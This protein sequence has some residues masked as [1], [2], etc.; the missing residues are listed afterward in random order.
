V[1]AI[2]KPL[3][4]QNKVI[5]ALDEWTSMNKLAITSG[6]AYYIDRNWALGEVQLAFDE[7]NLLFFSCFETLFRM[8]GQGPTYWSKASCTFEVCD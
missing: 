7:V 8:L 2:K 6:I 3:P 5:L 4:S 1:D